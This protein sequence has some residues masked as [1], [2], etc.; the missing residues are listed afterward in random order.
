MGELKPHK[1]FSPP[2]K[3][4]RRNHK[5]VRS[6]LEKLF[7]NKTQVKRKKQDPKQQGVQYINYFMV[8]LGKQQQNNFVVWLLISRQDSFVKLHEREQSLLVRIC[9]Q[10]TSQGCCPLPLFLNHYCQEATCISL[11]KWSMLHVKQ[12]RKKRGKKSRQQQQKSQ[13]KLL[14]KTQ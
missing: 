6:S 13:K 10:K 3:S 12:G 7:F 14:N 11:C 4:P 8:M 1:S 5:Y 2:F 9:K